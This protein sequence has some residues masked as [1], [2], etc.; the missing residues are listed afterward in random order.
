MRNIGIL[1][2]ALAAL[3][4]CPQWSQAQNRL[5]FRYK[6]KQHRVDEAGWKIQWRTNTGGITDYQVC[7]KKIHVLLGGAGEQIP[8]DIW[9]FTNSP[10]L[11]TTLIKANSA[12]ISY[13]TPA[14][15]TDDRMLLQHPSR[16]T[17]GDPVRPLWLGYTGWA[18]GVSSIV[19]RVRFAVDGYDELGTAGFNFAFYGGRMWG[20]ASITPRRITHLGVVVGPLLGM[21]TTDLKKSTV[22]DP[23]EWTTDRTA[24]TVNYGG[25]V[26]L[27][28]N[29]FGLM[30]SLGYETPLGPDRKQWIYNENLWFG[31]G[32]TAS[33]GIFG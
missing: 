1:Y 4:L 13:R 23:D 25:N 27:T 28:R 16:K 33:L 21:S 26:I 14:N 10:D 3:L 5:G 11:D 18:F 30:F 9:S 32:V 12:C 24:L 19:A 8:L 29:G 6:L 7:S 20:Q 2:A 22:K 17:L 15:T 31:V